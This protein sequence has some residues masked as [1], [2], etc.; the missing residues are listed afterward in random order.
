MKSVTEDVDNRMSG[1]AAFGT[2]IHLRIRARGNG[3]ERELRRPQEL[4]SLLALNRPQS[5]QD[6]Y[7]DAEG[8]RIC[9]RSRFQSRRKEW[10]HDMNRY[11]PFL[12]LTIHMRL[13]RLQRHAI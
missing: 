10:L 6:S 5:S 2:R 4:Q 7:C 12:S 11:L 8:S 13:T 9:E 1:R 3:L